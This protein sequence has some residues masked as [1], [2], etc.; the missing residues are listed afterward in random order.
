MERQRCLIDA[1]REEMPD[2]LRVSPA[3]A[4]MYLVGYLKNGMTSTCAARAAET[5]AVGTV[6]LS[7]MSLRPVKP[8]GLLLGYGAYTVGQIRIA[9]KQLSIALR[10]AAT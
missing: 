9:V 8:D 4:G 3:G 10:D 7:M 5:H 1:I 2:L 6:P